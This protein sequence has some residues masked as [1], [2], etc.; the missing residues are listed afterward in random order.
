MLLTGHFAIQILSIQRIVHFFGVDIEL[1]DRLRMI[2]RC[3]VGRY[4]GCI[5]RR[6]ET[7]GLIVGLSEFEYRHEKE[8]FHRRRFTY[9]ARQIDVVEF[10]HHGAI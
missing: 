5:V 9:D 8:Y 7:V 3:F 6:F 10:F 2:L 1:V 4:I